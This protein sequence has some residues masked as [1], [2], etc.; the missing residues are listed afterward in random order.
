MEK[1]NSNLFRYIDH[2]LAF[3]FRETFSSCCI[4]T[5]TRGQDE[6]AAVNI[7]QQVPNAGGYFVIWF[8]LWLVFLAESC[9]RLMLL[10]ST[11]SL[12]EKS[13]WVFYFFLS[14]QETSS[15]RSCHFGIILILAVKV[16][17][18]W[19]ALLRLWIFLF[20]TKTYVISVLRH[21]CWM[22]ETRVLLLEHCCHSGLLTHISLLQ[23]GFT[24]QTKVLLKEELFQKGLKCYCW[25]LMEFSPIN[26]SYSAI[27]L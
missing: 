19:L 16:C 10:E 27:C 7:G 14:I 24:Y 23:R 26:Q 18:I 15:Y 17:E 13:L 9:K 8:P 4:D 20:V 11:L 1:D 3:T 25:Q 12:E 2:L 5:L 22:N 21:L 6:G